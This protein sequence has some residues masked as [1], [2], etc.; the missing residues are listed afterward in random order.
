M[1]L[2]AKPTFGRLVQVRSIPPIV[3]LQLLTALDRRFLMERLLSNLISAGISDGYIPHLGFDSGPAFFW[4][5]TIKYYY[6]HHDEPNTYEGQVS[7]P[8]HEKDE[9]LYICRGTAI[10]AVNLDLDAFLDRS[11]SRNGPEDMRGDHPWITLILSTN[12]QNDIKRPRFL[13][14]AEAFLWAVSHEMNWIRREL[15]RVSNR[16]A[17]LAV[18]SVSLIEQQASRH[19]TYSRTISCSTGHIVTRCYLKTEPIQTRERISGLSSLC[20]L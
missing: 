15:R 13:N 8:L 5:F 14:A 19:L 16:I 18:P 3:A 7:G 6:L 4:S 17:S 11:K 12:Q 2:D 20:E 1:T 9:D 10:V